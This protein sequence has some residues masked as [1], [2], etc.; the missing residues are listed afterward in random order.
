VAVTGGP[1]QV[2]GESP[3]CYGSAC[4]GLELIADAQAGRDYEHAGPS[5]GG[6]WP[7][8]DRF[9]SGPGHRGSRPHP[10]HRTRK[11]ARLSCSP[12]ARTECF[13]CCADHYR[14]PW[15][16]PNSGCH[17]TRPRHTPRSSP[18]LGASTGDDAITGG[19]ETGI[20]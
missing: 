6:R 15:S 17:R 5:R 7:G 19:Q 2:N 13:G 12:N 8:L 10:D 1:G 3:I 20:L 16:P 11:T 18:Q 9:G 4:G 14:C